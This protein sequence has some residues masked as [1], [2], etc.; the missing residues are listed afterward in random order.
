MDAGYLLILAFCAWILLLL[1]LICFLRMKFL[2]EGRNPGKGF[3][4]SGEEISPFAQRVFRAHANCYENL[5]MVVGVVLVAAMTNQMAV[6]NPLA[7]VFLGLRILQSL[8][9]LSSGSRNAVGLRFMFYVG[10]CAILVYWLIRLWM[11]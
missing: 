6:I 8:T 7:I 9:H 11:H 2:A 3:S 1:L 5:P 4:P 10:Q